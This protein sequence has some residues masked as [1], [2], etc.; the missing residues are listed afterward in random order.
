MGGESA[1]GR[2]PSRQGG[3]RVE[4]EREREREESGGRESIKERQRGSYLRT[5]T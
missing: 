1:R 2:G 5:H 3:T 4:R